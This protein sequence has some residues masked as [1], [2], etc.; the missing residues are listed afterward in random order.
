MPVNLSQLELLYGKAGAREKFEELAIHL[1]RS[2]HPNVERT[3]IVHGDGGIDGHAGSL[4]SRVGVDVFQIKFF[5]SRVGEH[6][7]KQI[8]ESFQRCTANKRVKVKSWTLCL[9]IDM[10]V[11]EKRWFDGWKNRQR[12]TTLEIR[13]VWGACML[14]GLLYQEANRQLLREFFQLN[15]PLLRLNGFARVPVNFGVLYKLCFTIDGG[16]PGDCS[17]DITVGDRTQPAKWDETPNPLR[18]DRLDA[19]DAGLVPSTFHQR[20]H[21]DRPYQLPILIEAERQLM[22]FTAWWFGRPQYYDLPP[23]TPESSVAIT[24]RGSDLCWAHSFLVRDILSNAAS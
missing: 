3:R 8:R 17:C 23:L 15:A 11:D 14:E 21:A 24:I 20:L 10:S 13:P 16:D 18:G 7:K 6:Q 9:P 1:I 5:P 4:R 12:Q 19:F 22:V 2:Q